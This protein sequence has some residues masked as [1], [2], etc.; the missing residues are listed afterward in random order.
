MGQGNE[1]KGG[2]D[3]HLNRAAEL[4]ERLERIAPGAMYM[5]LM[6]NGLSSIE[7]MSLIESIAAL[8]AEYSPFHGTAL[9]S[10]I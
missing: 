1:Q 10:E 5:T 6:S 4:F 3:A 7:R 2:E 9:R 8:V